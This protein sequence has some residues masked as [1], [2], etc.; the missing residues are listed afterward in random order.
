MLEFYNSDDSD[1]GGDH[2]VVVVVLVAVV[3]GVVPITIPMTT[4]TDGAHNDDNLTNGNN[5]ASHQRH[6][7]IFINLQTATVKNYHTNYTVQPTQ[8]GFLVALITFSAN[9]FLSVL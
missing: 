9:H 5:T 7:Q 4:M 3:E 8:Q 2:V 1:D 6:N